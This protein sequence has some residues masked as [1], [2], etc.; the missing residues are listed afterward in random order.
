M[1]NISIIFKVHHPIQLRSYRFFDIGQDHYYYDDFSNKSSVMK[2]AKSCYLPMNTLLL[3]IIK[4]S[5]KQCKFS[6]SI[7]GTTIELFE[8]YTPEVI[9][10]FKALAETG[11]VEFLGETYAHSLSSI[12]SEIEFESQV[13]KH[14]AKIESLFGKKPQVFIN[15]ELIY[16]DGI[17]EQLH[18]LGFNGV[19]AE[20]AKQVLGWKS[21][22]F[23]YC[24]A[25]NPRQQVLLRNYKLSD[26]ISLRFSNIGWDQYPLT[27]EK[28]ISWIDAIPENE[29]ILNLVFDYKTFGNI[30]KAETGIFEFFKAFIEKAISAKYKI[31]TPSETIKAFQ[32]VSVLSV[33]NV[34][35]WSNEERDVS[36]WLGNNLQT[37]AN[38][39]LYALSDSMRFIEDPV[40]IE[41]WI[42]LQNNNHL[43]FM[44][45]NF[46]GLGEGFDK[47]PYATPYEAFINFMNILGDLSERINRAPKKEN[48]NTYSKEELDAEIEKHTEALKA[49]M[50]LKS[51]QKKKQK[52]AK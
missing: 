5:K 6:F 3:D 50:N 24:N 1:N 39:A 31:L 38:N 47:N 26:D 45:T 13:T 36:A 23:V 22:N 51:T 35:S 52:S 21:P 46:F 25:N 29:D 19:I 11:C 4:K 27:A 41:D 20:G 2:I 7:S 10:S 9:E 18:N 14:A 49:L 16:T 8:K 42:K 37:E 48:I 43:H 33:P 44:N 28:F 40:I 15:T 30:H 32:P 12:S 34:T 17:G